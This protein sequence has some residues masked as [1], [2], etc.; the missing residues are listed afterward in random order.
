MKRDIVTI[1]LNP[2]IDVTLWVDG[3]DDDKVNRVQKERREFEFRLQLIRQR[4]T[5]DKGT[6][7][8]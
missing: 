4:E 3:L 2:S 8:A 7:N 6:E 5:A 1:T